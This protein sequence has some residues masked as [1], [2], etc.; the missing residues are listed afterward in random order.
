MSEETVLKAETGKPRDLV[1]V[2]PLLLVGAGVA[3][4]L[5]N[6]LLDRLAP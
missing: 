5:V 4:L 6:L 2:A 1:S 3:I